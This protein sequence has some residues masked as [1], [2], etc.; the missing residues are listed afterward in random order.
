MNSTKNVVVVLVL[1]LCGNAHDSSAADTKKP[2]VLF[3]AAVLVANRGVSPELTNTQRRDLSAVLSRASGVID[4]ASENSKIRAKLNS[5]LGAKELKQ[6]NQSIF[7]HYLSILMPQNG[8]AWLEFELTDAERQQLSSIELPE[9]ESSLRHNRMEYLKFRL[10]KLAKTD[11]IDKVVGEEFAFRSSAMPLYF[12]WESKPRYRQRAIWPDKH[13]FP[14]CEPV[15]VV[16]STF[17]AD[18]LTMTL[19]QHRKAVELLKSY[20]N[21]GY[22]WTTPSYE[23]ELADGELDKIRKAAIAESEAIL[24]ETQLPRFRQI[25]LQRYLNA[26]DQIAIEFAARYLDLDYERDEVDD[27]LELDAIRRL[28]IVPAVAAT[29]EEVLGRDISN[30][31]GPPRLWRSTRFEAPKLENPTARRLLSETK[32]LNPRRSGR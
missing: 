2:K 3:R 17:V 6:L 25:V 28:A 10:S 14:D 22:I 19:E 21:R 5:I 1:A 18:E 11:E 12:S 30:I 13:S 29:V 24:T 4:P 9:L 20:K 26:D 8:F 32:K 31:V 15:R 27:K 16:A 7:Q 23:L